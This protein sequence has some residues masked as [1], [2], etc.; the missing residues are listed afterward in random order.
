MPASP[1]SFELGYLVSAQ[2]DM[3]ATIPGAERVDARTLSFV[4]NDYIEGFRKLRA[5]INIAPAR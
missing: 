5:M 3:G 1:Y 4:A 2:A